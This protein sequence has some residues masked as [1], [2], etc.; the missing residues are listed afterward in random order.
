MKFCEAVLL[1]IFLYGVALTSHAQ[2]ATPGPLR[3]GAAKVDITPSASELPKQYLGVLDHVYSRA[4]VVDNGTITAALVTVDVMAFPDPMWKRISQRIEKELGI[5]VKNILLAGIGTH[6]VPIGGRPVPGAAN[7]QPTPFEDKIVHSV[8]MAKENFQP[9]R[10]SWGTG[11][12]Y[13]NVNRDMYR[14]QDT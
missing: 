6:S 5:P 7:E 11:V 4:I 9:A 1:P 12:S 13:I 2:L 3:A 10:L 14:S 8:K